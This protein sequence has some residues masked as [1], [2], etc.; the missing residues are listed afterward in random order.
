M[1]DFKNKKSALSITSMILGIGALVAF[2]A[3]IGQI[4]ET[5]FPK[6]S[7]SS[8]SAVETTPR[9]QESSE[10]NNISNENYSPVVEEQPTEAPTEPPTE[11]PPTEPPVV[12]LD[13]SNISEQNYYEQANNL[14]DT[15]GNIYNVHSFKLGDPSTYRYGETN[16]YA[17]YY[18]GGNY[19]TLNGIIAVDDESGQN[20]LA[21]LIILCDDNQVYDT[22]SVG[23]AFAPVDLSVNVEGC[24]W[25]R[26]R[27]IDVDG[28]GMGFILSDFRLE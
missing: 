14:K 16:G 22:G 12:Y 19:K 10:V 3:N 26:I 5:W 4:K 2:L 27:E 21:E 6:E 17:T 11:P 25:L 15:I 7:E 24:Q 8:S 1:G 13:S 9:K 20:Q 28:S 23:R 18:L